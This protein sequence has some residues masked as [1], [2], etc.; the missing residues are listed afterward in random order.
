MQ[1]INKMLRTEYAGEEIITQAVYENSVWSYNKEETSTSFAF[2]PKSE[3]AVVL[4][5]GIS[6]SMIDINLLKKERG[7]HGSKTLRIY[8]CNAL[9]RDFDPDFLIV[10]RDSIAEE[11]ATK[12]LK[13]GDYCKNNI[14]YA[15]VKNILDYPGNFHVIPQNPGWNSGAIAAYLA[16]FDGHRKVYLIGHD[17]IDTPGA[18]YNLYTGSNGYN[19]KSTIGAFYETCMLIVF[20]TYS[21][22]DFVFVNKTGKGNFPESWK[23]CLNVRRLGLRDFVL[24]ADI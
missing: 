14:V 6:R 24:E 20:K 5:N 21:D 15:S 16:C 1:K 7:F 11:I 4:G 22:T 9:Y 18:D 23:A 12:N 2:V 3:S 8:G 19:D 17:I 10:T 13:S